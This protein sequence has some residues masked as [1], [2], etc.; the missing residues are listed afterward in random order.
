MSNQ[1]NAFC[2]HIQR[3]SLE[4]FLPF[5]CTQMPITVFLVSRRM[6]VSLF[7]IKTAATLPK[8]TEKSQPFMFIRWVRRK[9]KKTCKRKNVS[10][11]CINNQKR[12]LFGMQTFQG[13]DSFQG[14]PHAIV[15]SSLHSPLQSVKQQLL[16]LLNRFFN[17]VCPN[18]L[19]SKNGDAHG[20]KI[21]PSL[22]KFWIILKGSSI[23]S[24]EWHGLVI[25]RLIWD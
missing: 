19:I 22:R 24:V 7:P 21:P 13:R 9:I 10:S 1:A 16:Y 4:K 8:T 17:Q 25:V 3:F 23:F 6:P 5:S 11:F 15:N 2:P 18:T 20:N 14:L 12:T